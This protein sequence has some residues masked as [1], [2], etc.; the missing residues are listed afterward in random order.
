MLPSFYR[1]EVKRC[2]KQDSRSS[3]IERRRKM[4]TTDRK[5]IGKKAAVLAVLIG[6]FSGF[7]SQAAGD[8]FSTA[9]SQPDTASER[10]PYPLF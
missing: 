7:T 10:T 8:V 1:E 5:N 4:G 2:R 3:E 6:V 9:D